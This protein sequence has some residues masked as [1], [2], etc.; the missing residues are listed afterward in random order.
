[1]NLFRS[2]EHVHHWPQFD[3]ATE[4]G[5][6]ALPHLA[7][8]LSVGHFTRRLDANHVSQGFHAG[9][10]LEALTALGRIRYTTADR[11]EKQARGAKE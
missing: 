1:M 9:K 11:T 4:Q 3:T 8:L 6:L 2:V 10:F 5:I 7:A